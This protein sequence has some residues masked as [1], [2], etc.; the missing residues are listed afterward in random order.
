MQH[1]PYH[2]IIGLVSAVLVLLFTAVPVSAEDVALDDFIQQ[3][4]KHSKDL[5][6]AEKD[7]EAAG[8]DRSQ[9][10]SLALPHLSAA[11]QYTRNLHDLYMYADLSALSG[12]SGSTSKLRTNRNNEYQLGV[13]LTQ[14][15][16][17]G[18][19]FNAIK[20]A[21]EYQHLTDNVYD[22]TYQQLITGARQAFYQ[23]LLLREVRDVAVQSEN[24]AHDNYMDVKKA[25][26]NGLV[27]EFA[28]LQA[29]AR[30]RDAIPTTTGARRDYDL[31]IISLKNLAGV[32]I[33]QEFE[34]I[35]LLD[36]YPSMPDIPSLDTVL[37]N[38]PDY[39]ALKWEEKLRGTNVRAER[40]NYFPTLMG[41][42][43]YGYSAQSD[44][45]ALDNENHSV[46]VGLALSIPIFNGGE[47]RAKVRKA[48]IER[49]Q[50]NLEIQRKRDD[51]EKELHSVRLRLEE[52][53][54]K[55]RSAEASR[56]T[57]QKAFDIAE[58]ISASGLITQLELKDSRVTLDKATVGYY[59][60][61]FEYL[62]AYFDWQRVIGKI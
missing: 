17:S 26:D 8:A 61:I 15:L 22:A 59:S 4:E 28:L 54:D 36:D 56:A 34:P 43:E 12:E 55:I 30:Y 45:F 52:A 24:N 49:Q 14:T 31:A 51:I 29:E 42:A 50:T 20:A 37:F 27:S 58:N 21:G 53:Y 3:V 60:A 47:T 6:L 46:T 62:V 18:T 57:A 41:V 32:P 44:E 9:A 16:F 25:Y 1:K 33:E 13:S 40:A 48:K 2:T 38:R 10:L 39:N 5:K 23:A 19:V 11:A 35:G 7:V